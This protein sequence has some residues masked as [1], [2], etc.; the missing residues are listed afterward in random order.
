MLK[1]P[2]FPIYPVSPT[3][4]TNGVWA[5]GAITAGTS[6][7]WY[8][9]IATVGIDYY[10]W[11]N[12]SGGATNGDGTKTLNAK[13]D[14]YYPDGTF[15]VGPYSAWNTYDNKF[16]ATGTKI[17]IKV[18]SQTSGGTGTFGFALSTSSTR[19]ST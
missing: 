19:P 16:T 7:V 2:I 6:E 18:T 8:E 13:A 3:T 9:F 15:I 4:L 5:N 17:Y 12:E 10:F 14:L 1:R 11:L